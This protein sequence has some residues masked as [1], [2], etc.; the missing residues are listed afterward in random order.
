MAASTRLG[1]AGIRDQAV[2][3]NGRFLY[4]LDADAQRVH[5]WSVGTDGRLAEIGAFE[6]VPPTVA[7][8]AAS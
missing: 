7:G 1:N 4:A 5:G 8:L 2:S 3:S 6:G